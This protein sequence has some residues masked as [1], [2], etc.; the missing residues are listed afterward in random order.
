MWLGVLV[1]GWVVC[2][3]V[4]TDAGS[5]C[6]FK[7]ILTEERQGDNREGEETREE[8]KKK[9]RDNMKREEKRRDAEAGKGGYGK[10]DNRNEERREQKMMV[11]S[12]RGQREQRKNKEKGTRENEWT[13]KTIIHQT[14][15]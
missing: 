2:V 8:G 10:V 14:S 3:C 7:Y 5:V 12:R 1:S 11:R 6:V 9:I 4:F 13:F 15:Y